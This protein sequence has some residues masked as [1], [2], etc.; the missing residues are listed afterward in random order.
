M[1]TR[2]LVAVLLSL[3]IVACGGNSSPTAPPPPASDPLAGFALSGDPSSAN[4]ATWTYRQQVDGVSYDLQG[5]LLKPQ[6]PGPFPAVIISHGAGGN[7]GGYGRAIARV[8]VQWG[9]VCIA[10]NYTHAGNVPLGS[11]GTSNDA[12]ASVANVQRARRL[13]G[14]LGGLGYVDISRVGLHGHSMG[15]FVTSATAGAH[16]DLFRAASH[17]AGGIRPDFVSAPAPTESQIAGIRA[18]YQMHHGDRDFVVLLLA[19]QLLDAVLTA[20]GVDHE[21]V[22]YPGADHDDVS[23][24]PTMLDRVRGW[25]AA[26]GMGVGLGVRP[27]VRP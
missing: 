8:M 13:V 22:V 2:S 25:Y 1:G 4:G 3:A 5:I 20:R 12:G 7:A 9:L 27:G 18:P 10:T 17:T 21:L 6:G 23:L 14:I 15:A 19:D 26:K 11:P 24:S 16:P